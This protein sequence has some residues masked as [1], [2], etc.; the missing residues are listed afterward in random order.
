MKIY[1]KKIILF[2]IISFV[3]GFIDAF[4]KDKNINITSTIF[5]IVGWINCMIFNQ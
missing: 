4:F 1:I 3:G 5:T 2:F